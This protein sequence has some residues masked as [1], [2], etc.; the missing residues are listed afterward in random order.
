[1]NKSIYR[2]QDLTAGIN[3]EKCI[4]H[5]YRPYNVSP[6]TTNP[7]IP[8]DCHLN[9]SDGPCSSIGGEC[10]CK[11]G[12]MGPRCSECAAGYK[13]EQCTKCSC[14]VRG[15]MHG[16]ECESHCQCKVGVFL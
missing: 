6:E 8:C 3:C 7:C 13:G 15:T 2:K 5:Y 9:G 11:P 14:D 12:F 10:N 16:G 4:P 1:M